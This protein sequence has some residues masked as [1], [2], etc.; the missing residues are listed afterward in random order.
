M[1]S[2][3][4]NYSVT[5]II[6]FGCF[7]VFRTSKRGSTVVLC[8]FQWLDGFDGVNDVGPFLAASRADHAVTLLSWSDLKLKE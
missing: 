3:V 2:S 6:C 7:N 4:F 8:C 5:K 1:V